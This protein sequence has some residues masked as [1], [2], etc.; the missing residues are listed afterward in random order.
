MDIAAEAIPGADHT[1]YTMLRAL[2]TWRGEMRPQLILHK[3]MAHLPVPTLFTWGDGDAFAPPSVGQEMAS[4]MPDARIEDHPR[5]RS[6]GA[7]WQRPDTVAATINQFLLAR[8]CM[9]V[10]GRCQT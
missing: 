2:T 10:A 8:P 6:P 5:H 9:H 3:D 4:S 1:S 7:A